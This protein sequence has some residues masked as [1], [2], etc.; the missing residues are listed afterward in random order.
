V[1]RT[2]YFELPSLPRHSCSP[3]LQPEVNN[4]ADWCLQTFVRSPGK[5]FAAAEVGSFR[6]PV[7]LARGWKKGLPARCTPSRSRDFAAAQH[8]LEA[9][10]LKER[11]VHLALTCVPAGG[12]LSGPSDPQYVL[13]RD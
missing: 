3:W 9:A 8:R 7:L 4:R 6:S 13:N 2:R 10:S 11:A 12:S 1:Q 5:R